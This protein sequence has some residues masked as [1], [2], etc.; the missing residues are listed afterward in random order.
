MHLFFYFLMQAL[1]GPWTRHKTYEC[2]L[3]VRLCTSQATEGNQEVKPS[4]SYILYL[5][6]LRKRCSLRCSRLMSCSREALGLAR[7]PSFAHKRR[8]GSVGAEPTERQPRSLDN[9]IRL[10]GG[11]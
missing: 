7:C 5:S 8:H 2:A 1:A 4:S 11:R 3:S 10:S 6:P 9:S